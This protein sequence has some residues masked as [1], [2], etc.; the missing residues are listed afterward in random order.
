LRAVSLPRTQKKR[1]SR[2]VSILPAIQHSIIRDETR[3]ALEEKEIHVKKTWML[4]LVVAIALTAAPAAM[5]CE[6]CKPALLACG[7]A[8]TGWE[9]CEWTW[10]NNCITHTACTSAAAPTE[11]LAAEFAVASVERLDGSL[12]EPQPAAAEPLVASLETPAPV[13]PR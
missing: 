12:N 2:N 3:D 8:A 11:S 7:P 1:S 10:D 5:A 6:R 13:T 4:L 9:Y